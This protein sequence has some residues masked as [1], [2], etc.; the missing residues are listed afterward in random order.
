MSGPIT[1]TPSPVPQTPGNK[2]QVVQIQ[3]LPDALQSTSRAIR[4]QGEVVQ[5]NSDGSTRIK[6]P[7]GNIDVTIRGK[8]LQ[9]GAQVEVDVPPGNPPRTVTVRPTAVTQPTTQTPQ[10]PLPPTTTQPSAPLPATPP[11]Q[12]QQPATQNPSTPAQ[13][14]GATTPVTTTGTAQ[15]STTMP[16]S[17]QTLPPD[18]SATGKPQAP[19]PN[20]YQPPPQGVP[21]PA[22]ELPPLTNGQIVRLTPLPSV[23]TPSLTQPTVTTPETIVAGQI[24]RASFTAGLI[25]QSVQ[26][27]LQKALI[28]T[29]QNPKVASAQLPILN[30]TPQATATPA[31]IAI[32]TP[33][34]PSQTPITLHDLEAGSTQ[35]LQ[36]PIGNG[37]GILT[38]NFIQDTKISPRLFQLDVKILDI[39]PAGVQ[40]VPIVSPNENG[41]PVRTPNPVFQTQ[42]NTG[43]IVP[44]AT[45]SVLTG[46]VTGF[47]PQNLP[48]VTIQWPTGALSQ[49]FVLQFAAGNLTPGSQILLQPQAQ[50]AQAT[51]GTSSALSKLPLMEASTIWPVLD[52]M[53]Q[54]FAQAAPQMAQMMARIIPSPSNPAQMGPAALLFVATLRSGDISGWMN[55]RKIDALTKMGKDTLISRLTAD[56]DNVMRANADAPGND[57]KSYPLPMLWQNEISKVLLHVKHENDPQDRESK[58]GT[59]R[60]IMDLTLTRMGDVQLDGLLR[61]KRLDLVVRTEMPISASMQD[62]MQTAYAKALDG[63]E[64]FGELGFQGDLKHAVRILRREDKLIASA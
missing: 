48:I 61:G 54:S 33:A 52:E 58:D 35:T 17:S 22:A 1:P 15:S 37:A 7:E 21:P 12:G 25:A 56:A 27:D 38:E 14:A 13:P 62:A 20:S 28:Q 2:G 60:F 45:P 23:Q 40:L 44:E 24:S 43:T 34:Q 59:T 9:Q 42:A 30:G 4:L 8:Q 11:A 10:P 32:T 26:P 41:I 57:W 5:Q 49:N 53:F 47:T 50:T 3:S 46:I 63:T 6:T 16:T 19:L 18:V 36:G 51:A 39:K 55:D 64:I 29:L 31:P